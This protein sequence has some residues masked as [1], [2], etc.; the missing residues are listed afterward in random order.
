MY[1]SAL[2]PRFSAWAAAFFRQWDRLVKPVLKLG[3]V[4]LVNVVVIK[5]FPVV[6][7]SQTGI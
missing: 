1:P 2:N 5:F 4:A 6:S 7:V 3:R